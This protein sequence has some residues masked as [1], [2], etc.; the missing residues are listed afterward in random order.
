MTGSVPHARIVTFRYSSWSCWTLEAD[1]HNPL[2]T[3]GGGLGLPPL[4]YMVTELGKWSPRQASRT[5]PTSC[6]AW[7]TPSEAMWAHNASAHL[8]QTEQPCAH[9]QPRALFC[10]CPWFAFLQNCFWP[11][12][13]HFI[14][15]F[16]LQPF[17]KEGKELLWGIKAEIPKLPSFFWCVRKGLSICIIELYG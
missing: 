7:L 17:L 9:T 16:V 1:A 8:H 13:F 3:W 6:L 4:T 14:Y 11:C 2:G 12:I 10:H 5:Q 15:L